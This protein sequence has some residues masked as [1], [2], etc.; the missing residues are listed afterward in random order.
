MWNLKSKTNE[1]IQQNR[2]GLTDLEN[3]L[4]VTSGEKEGR[5]SMVIG[6]KGIKRHK[7]LCQNKYDTKIQ[8]TAQGK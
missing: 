8:C 4:V 3:K 1:C 7:L 6:I 2:N 5:K